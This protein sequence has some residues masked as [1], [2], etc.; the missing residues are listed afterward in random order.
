M[1]SMACLLAYVN[2]W[3]VIGPTDLCLQVWLASTCLHAF[4][5]VPAQLLKISNDNVYMHLHADLTLCRQ[6]A[7]PLLWLCKQ[8]SLLWLYQTLSSDQ[9]S[10]LQ[11]WPAG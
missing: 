9:Q 7:P 1:H 10:D 8:E 3:Q 11:S 2:L 4:N 5:A 6:P